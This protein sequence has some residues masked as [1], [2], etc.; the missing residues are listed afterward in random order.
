MLTIAPY[1]Q[2]F[3]S[4]EKVTLSI[5]SKTRPYL[6]ERNC[7]ILKILKNSIDNTAVRDLL[8]F[9]QTSNKEIT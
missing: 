6:S 7:F 9:I 1:W 2:N 4:I 8:G 5:K 3:N